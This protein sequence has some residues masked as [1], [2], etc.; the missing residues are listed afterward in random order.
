MSKIKVE[1]GRQQTANSKQQTANSRQ[2]TAQDMPPIYPQRWRAL[3]PAEECAAL[4]PAPRAPCAVR[5]A[6]D[7]AP[8]PQ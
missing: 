1:G 6:P 3:T 7:T 8:L 4:T 2:Q 5:R